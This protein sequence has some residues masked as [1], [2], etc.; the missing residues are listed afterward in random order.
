MLKNYFIIAV[1]SLWKNKVFTAINVLGLAIGISASFVIYLLVHH[2]FSFDKF[3]PK[4]DSTYRVVVDFSFSGEHFANSGVPLPLCTEVPR[5]IPGLNGAAPFIHWDDAKISVPKTANTGSG[6]P[7]HFKH[8]SRIAFVQPGYFSMFQH[9]W[10][11]GTPANSL[12]QPYQAVLTTTGAALYFPHRTNQE[13]IGRRFS[14]NDSINLAVTGIV[15]ELPGRTDLNFQVFISYATLTT[16]QLRTP[17]WDIWNDFNS[18]TQLYVHLAPGT[19]PANVALAINKLFEKH[20]EKEANSTTVFKLQPLSDVHFNDKYGNYSHRLAH[21]PTLYG[22]LAIA[23][24]L[25]LLGCIN[26]INLTTARSSQRAKETGIRKTMGSSK[27]QLILQFLL[28]TFLLTLLATVLSLCLTPVI[29]KLF[30]NFLPE[31]LQYSFTQEPVILLYLLSLLAF[32]T[33]VSGLYPAMVLAGFKPVLVLKNQAFAGSSTTRNAWIRKTLTVSQ[34]VVAQVFIIATILVGKQISY[35]LNKD[36][37]MRR[38]AIVYVGLDYRD[39]AQQK[40]PYFVNQLKAIPGIALVSAAT[41]PPSSESAWT[42]TVKYADS[43]GIREYNVNVMQVDSNYLALYGLKLAAGSNLRH[44]DTATEVMINETYARTLGFSNPSDAI[45]KNIQWGSPGK[46]LPIKGI[47]ADFHLASLHEVIK[48]IL[49]G[50]DSQRFTTVSILLKDQEQTALKT[51]LAKIEAVWKATYPDQDFNY[52]F[53]D[54]SVAAF[55]EKEQA[56]ATLLTW[57][58]GLAVF[59][60][61]LGLLGLVIFTTARRTKEIGVRKVL[62]ASVTEIVQLL[63]KDFIRLVLLAFILAI[64]I[65][66]YGM[67]QWLQNFA[68]RTSM[69]WW[70]FAATGLLMILVALLT[71]SIQTIRAASVNPVK[72]LRSE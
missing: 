41:R 53:F 18:E 51:T 12:Q 58:T 15:E 70:V 21:K 29:L 47:L 43:T 17:K 4:G 8:Q 30:S 50:N 7:T 44:G 54:Q 2:D 19:Q 66:W 13:I 49:V 1:R 56:T 67:H 59:I 42:T 64:P 10:K 40:R 38:E 57:A 3:H 16:P 11:N 61:C 63:S 26:F 31:G 52:K 55:Y 24:F 22:M 69:S 27:R 34:F 25:L 48:P 32:V 23:G 14:I 46:T 28:E 60:S 71:L 37:G 6:E 65:A 5:T 45:G 36:I 35:T 68:Y 62:G 33:L 20:E 72:S 9:A 39:A